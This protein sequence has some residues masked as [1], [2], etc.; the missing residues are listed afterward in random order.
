VTHKFAKYLFLATSALG[1][2][3]LPALAITP[4]C[5]AGFTVATGTSCALDGLTFDFENV[6]FNPSSGTPAPSL[7]L[8]GLT[9]VTGDDFVLDFSVSV[10]GETMPPAADDLLLDY[11]VTGG[12]F[13][14]VDNSFLS[15]GSGTQSLIEDV[16][17]DPSGLAGGAPG[18]LLTLPLK[19]T[20]GALQFSG[21]FG[22]VGSV[23]IAKDFS[24]LTSQF[25]D[26]I[27][28]TP[29]PSSLGLLLFGAFGIVAA[30]RRK[31][32]QA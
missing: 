12:S 29:E 8:D 15:D 27:V 5:V 7:E 1:L 19:N 23:Y 28:S 16:Y 6:Q 3:A 14:Q 13:S 21:T 11:T 20:S 25:S 2:S 4:P 18:T 26:S 30:A 22:P 17:S 32:R 31:F 9:G 24:G 10:G